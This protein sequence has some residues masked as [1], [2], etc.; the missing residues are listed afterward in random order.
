MNP[1]EKTQTYGRLV[2]RRFRRSGLGMAGLIVLIGLAV[3]VVLGPFLAPMNPDARFAPYQP[4]SRIGLDARGLYA[5]NAMPT[6]RDDPVT[7]QPL[8]S[9]NGAEKVRLT[10]WARTEPYRLLG[11][12]TLDRRLIGVSRIGQRAHLLGADRFGRDIFSRGLVATRVSLLLALTVVTL[13]TLTG[14]LVGATAGYMGGAV[15]RWLQRL[16]DVLL[17]F[18]QLP[19]YLTL[20]AL[21][22]VTVSSG[23]FVAILIA[24]LSVLGWAGLSREVRGKTLMLARM[25]YVR[26]AIAMGADDRRIIL[27][28]IAPNLMSHVLVSFTLTL[29]TIV[30]LESFLGFLGLA[31]KPPMISWGLMLQDVSGYSAIGSHPFIL[32]PVIFVFVTV[33]AFN[34]VGDALR[35]A[36]DPY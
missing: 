17:A 35:D 27:H 12:I 29:P 3:V 16:V 11:P 28:H 8:L 18:P 36:V 4:P 22:P 33:F 15:D 2:W 23:L 21:I 7:L 1:D 13:T 24:T 26:A 25:D 20:G 32:S 5:L 31:V 30:L 14:L 6:G 10:L 19:L 9:F 34:A